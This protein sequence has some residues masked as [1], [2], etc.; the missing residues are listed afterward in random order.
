MGGDQSMRPAHGETRL[1]S[2]PVSRIREGTCNH[3]SGVVNRALGRLVDSSDE[4]NVISTMWRWM[5]RMDLTTLLVRPS[6][7]ALFGVGF[8][9]EPSVVVCAKIGG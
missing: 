9:E 7:S 1:T 6:A 8:A 3:G 4:R 2:S 5:C